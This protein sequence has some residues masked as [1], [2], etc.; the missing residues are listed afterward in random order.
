MQDLLVEVEC[1]Q[2]HG[3]LQPTRPLP[4]LRS[5]VGRERPSCLLLLECRLV[6]L[7]DHIIESVRVVYPEIVVVRARQY[8][9][10]SIMPGIGGKKE[11]F[12]SKSRAAMEM[13]SRNILV[14]TSP[15]TLKLVEDAVILVQ[16]AQLSS[17][18]I[19]NGDRL[20]WPRFHIDVPNLQREVV[21]R[22]DVSSITTEFHVRNGRDNLRE[23]GPR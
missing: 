23:E 1:F 9:P 6:S 20:H 3:F 7:E 17:Q 21:T 12:V 13:T 11:R 2:L 5:L 10:D 4:I 8:V 19:V 16:I 14:I 22:E 15:D 18:M